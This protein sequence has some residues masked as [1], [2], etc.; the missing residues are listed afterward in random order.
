VN[1]KTGQSVYDNILPWSLYSTLLLYAKD[2]A[3]TVYVT[4]RPVLRRVNLRA[5]WKEATSASGFMMHNLFLYKKF[6]TMT[7]RQV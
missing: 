2:P 6:T 4:P 1:L 5:T 7:L 3:G